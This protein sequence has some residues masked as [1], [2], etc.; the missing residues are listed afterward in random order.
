MS[1]Y[2]YYTKDSELYHHGIKGQKWG[3]RRFQNEDGSLTDAGKRRYGYKIG[4]IK[5][6]FGNENVYD[7][8]RL[9]KKGLKTK[10]ID[11]DAF[12]KYQEERKKKIEEDI[13]KRKE[14]ESKE[15]REGRKLIEKA[16]MIDQG[17]ELRKDPERSKR[18]AITGLKAMISMGDREITKENMRDWIE[19]YLWED[20]TIGMPTVSDLANQGYSAKQI[21]SMVTAARN[22][23]HNEIY[24]DD[25][26]PGYFGLNEGYFGDKFIEACVKNR[27]K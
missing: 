16:D 20:Q 10:K 25:A 14:K 4:S 24:S 22:M 6:P 27:Q 1:Y 21:K 12:N 2:G 19:W 17:P 7:E 8:N 26:P 13:R 23:D 3:I 9:N 5:T 15:I 11:Q 18:A